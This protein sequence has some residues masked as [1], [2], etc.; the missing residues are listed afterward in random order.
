M[1][2]VGKACGNSCINVNLTCHQPAGCACN[3]AS[4]GELDDAALLVDVN[5]I[6]S[7]ELE[8]AESPSEPCPEVAAEEQEDAPLAADVAELGAR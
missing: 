5:V 6:D 4:P 2:T 3:A 1:C 7:E 8:A